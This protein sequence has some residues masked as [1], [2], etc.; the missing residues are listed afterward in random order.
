MIKF[1]PIIFFFF[2]SCDSNK[3]LET[4][5][6]EISKKIEINQ[7]KIRDLNRL[8]QNAFD[9]GD[10]TRAGDYRKEIFE[11][12]KEDAKLFEEQKILRKKLSN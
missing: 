2:I 12:H 10:S 9:K 1:L 7:Q 6:K 5:N 4:R 8:Y 11:L 3:N